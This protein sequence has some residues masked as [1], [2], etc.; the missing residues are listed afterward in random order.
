MNEI[1]SVLPESV[2][3]QIAAGEVI[4][5][6]A[7]VLKE[8]VENSL[9]AGA[10]NIRIEVEEAGRSLLRVSDDGCGMSPMDARMA[11]ERHATS[12]IHSVDDLFKLS[13]MGFRGEALASIVSV[14]QVELVTR[15]IEDYVATK[16]LFEGSELIESS[17]VAASVGSTFTVRNLFFNVP[18]RRRFLKSD[19]TELNNLIDQ[20]EKIALVYPNVNFS[21]FS[22]GKPI[23]TLPAGSLKKRI[24]ATKGK[25]LEKGIIPIDFK[26]DIA[27]ITGFVG[28]PETARKRSS[29]QFFF[30]NNRFMKHLGFHKAVMSVYEKL[31]PTGYKPHY[32]LYFAVDPSRIDVNIHPTKTEIKFLDEQTIFKLLVMVIKQALSK[33]FKLPVLDFDAKNIVDIPSYN[34]NEKIDDSYSP[35]PITDPNYNP[36]EDPTGI[37]WTPPHKTASHSKLYSRINYTTTDWQASLDRFIKEDNPSLSLNEASSASIFSLQNKI[38]IEE[39]KV[40]DIPKKTLPHLLLFEGLF[41]L[42]P[43]STG[44][45]LIDVLRAKERFLY[46]DI[47]KKIHHSRQE[48]TMQRLL[49]PELLQFSPRE[50]LFFDE[51]IYAF[52]E[53]GFEISPLGNGGYSLLSVP[54]GLEENA[55]DI[56]TTT[57]KNILEK[58]GEPLEELAEELAKNYCKHQKSRLVAINSYE[59]ADALIARLFSLTDGYYTPSGK[60]IFRILKGSELRNLIG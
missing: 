36:F 51:F 41:L 45:A 20:F 28:L 35:E 26:N 57:L 49:L 29:F 17:E 32:F 39:E 59:D 16:L 24:V 25:L 58:E 38:L 50:A 18:A 31:I 48:E 11:F 5:R 33:T 6:P 53:F 54:Q 34:P 43:L 1:I 12:K 10:K 15:K 3:N 13:S 52:E 22:E 27:T 7:S 40:T 2:A 47:L 4:Q 46:D 60:P 55:A 9:D 37:K 14:A 21:F 44:L 42:T 8:L 19:R 23:I 56:L 30:V